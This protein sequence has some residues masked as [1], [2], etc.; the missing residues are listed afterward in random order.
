MPLRA[1]ICAESERSVIGVARTRRPPAGSPGGSII[2]AV[3]LIRCSG[4]LS[5]SRWIVRS[6]PMLAAASASEAAC[7]PAAGA[8][9]AAGA[10]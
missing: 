2:C 6:S 7:V 3:F 1:A 5:M 4:L 9:G 8:G 10:P